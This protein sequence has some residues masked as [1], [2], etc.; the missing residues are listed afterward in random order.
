MD[1][2]WLDLRFACRSIVRR[3]GFAAL[4][5][6][7]LALGIGVN[8]VAFS[9]INALLLRPFKVADADR[10][11]WI[12]IG[13]D[14]SVSLAEYQ[15]LVRGT[16]AFSAIAAEGRLPVSL[17]GTNGAR[18][19]WSLLVSA[20]Y[21]ETVGAI[22]ETGR[23]FTA[24]DVRGADLPAVVSHRFWTDTLGGGDSIAGRTVTINGRAF[25]I[26]GVLRDDFQGPGG[27]YAPDV[28]L[29]LDRAD[30][31]NLPAN[32][33]GDERWL[34][35]FGRL[36]EGTTAAQATSELSAMAHAL[37]PTT[38]GE[39][40]RSGR[41][42][43]MIDGHPDLKAIATAAWIAMAVVGVVL[44]IACFNVAALLMA[45]ATERQREIG[46]R[47]A[48]GASRARI[49]RQLATEGVVLATLGGIATL[50][51]ASWS[52]SL[53]STFS[54]P[55]PIPQR[56][57]LGVDRTLIAFTAVLVLIAG[58]FP[59]ILP[60]L[61]AT[62]ANLLRSL[63]L[64][65]ALG[66]GPSR[67]R[68]V[69]VVAQVAGSTLFLAAA[70]LFVRSFVNASA[71]DPGFNT[72]NTVVLQLSP[73]LY[74]Y[75]DERAR[76]LVEDLRG[77][78]ASL[79]GVA[80]ASIADRVPYYIGFPKTWKY[81]TDGSDCRSGG[82]RDATVFAVGSTG[83]FDALGMRIRVGRD[84][85]D[86]DL[87]T[88]SRVVI[89]EHLASQL[90]PGESAVGRTLKVGTEG[91]TVEVIGVVSDVTY[92]SNREG[93]T[94]YIYRPLASGEWA[95]G[96]S[97][98]ARATGDPRLLLAALNEQARAADPAM[99]VTIATMQE[100]MKVPLWPMRTAAGFFVVC[101]VLALVL[102]TIGLFGVLYFAVAQRTR[103]FGI[104]VALGATSRRVMQVVLREG[105][106]LAVAGV[107]LGSAGALV[108]AR[109]VS[110]MLVGVSPSDPVS[111]SVAAAI[112]IGVA[113]VACA[114]P[115][116]RATRAD[117]ILALRAE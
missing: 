39:K 102:A 60:A 64:E 6:V 30:V 112:E 17:Q 11:G 32:L 109:L 27:L 14:E 4:A 8:T 114:L 38:P 75:D 40:P 97:V 110:R 57:H 90:W 91:R 87:T 61:Q 50:I 9:A 59:A 26:V 70:L 41:F 111:F 5:V 54:L 116:Y 80:R 104:R 79:N 44:L 16:K 69:L 92:R 43:R 72:T 95:P 12:T 62:R 36:S 58:I 28:W 82:C 47:S 103:E 101:G 81:A 56:L 45:R 25:S 23:L 42:N 105:L 63:R 86:A 1:S 117:P 100:R 15:E 93:A 73:S 113:L 53:L 48:L 10:I 46:V 55:A 52:G 71:F 33:R 24:R 34:T 108:A 67:A 74:G 106:T 51:V 107:V 98:V 37:A 88:D 19:G 94:A 96:V 115:A 76:G 89:G 21:L 13:S 29:P 99:P 2:L 65:S 68:N 77:R 22:P 3:P 83:H 31:L 7:T 35:L 18:Q 84:F 78:I 66:G 85:T 20:N 49:L